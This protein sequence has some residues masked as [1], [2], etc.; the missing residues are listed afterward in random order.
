M[1][2]Q[3]YGWLYE[4]PPQARAALSINDTATY[5]GIG[6]SMVYNLLR[7][8]MIKNVHIRGRNVVLRQSCDEYL[9]TLSE[10]SNRI[11]AG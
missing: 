9:Q 7:D 3:E 5:L 4:M 2:T 1:A 10:N 11:S 8:G 6:R